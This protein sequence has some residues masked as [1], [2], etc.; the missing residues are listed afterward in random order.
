MKEKENLAPGLYLVATPIGNLE[1]FSARGRRI[2]EQVQWIGA[3]DTR[4]SKK[5][6][7]AYGLNSSLISLHE[8]SSSEKIA[9]L[10]ARLSAGKS[11]A[12]VSDAGTPGICDPGAALVNAAVAAGISVY[13]VPGASAPLALLSVSGF[14]RSDFSFHGFFPRENKERLAFAKKMREGVHVFFESPHRFLSCL[15]FLAEH[16]SQEKL[17]IGRELTKLYETIHRGTPA[18]LWKSLRTQ[19]ARGEYVLALEISAKEE[20]VSE[21]DIRLLLEELAA[22]GADQKI[23]VK[24]AQSHGLPR[25]QAYSLALGL[26]RS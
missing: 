17:V 8:H 23:L 19:E 1:D 10:V 20:A 16:F 12:Y 9:E 25:N 3:E 24:V 22:L 13:P 21:S 15:E 18:D 5:L 2:L 7:Q 14:E 26:Q 4:E 11:G 6:L